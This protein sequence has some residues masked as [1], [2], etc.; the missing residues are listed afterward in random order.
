M[1]TYRMSDREGERQRVGIKI[2]MKM[3]SAGEK[4]GREESK[5]EMVSFL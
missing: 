1:D 2:K 4:Y 3:R 5:K